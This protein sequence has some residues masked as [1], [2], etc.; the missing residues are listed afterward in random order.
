MVPCSTEEDCPLP[1]MG[2]EHGYCLFPCDDDDADC[3]AWPGYTCQHQGLFCEADT[4]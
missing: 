1:E 3:A 4:T 2:C